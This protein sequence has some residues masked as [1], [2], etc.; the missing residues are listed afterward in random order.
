MRLLWE[1][2]HELRS[3]SKR[4]LKVAGVTGPQ[5][6]AV[7]MIGRFPNSS[8]G[9]LA[10]LLHV[11]P[12]TLTGVLARLER[13]GLLERHADPSD[14]R[15]SLLRLSKKGATVDAMRKGTVEDAV[16]KTFARVPASKVAAA[17]DVLAELCAVLE[18]QTEARADRP[19]K[20]AR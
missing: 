20:R 10:D 5:R 13:D 17:R 14:R 12:S 1:L 11:H 18:K 4:L 9:D 6:L 7:R 15:R 8:A 3:A 2:D 16:K 19:R